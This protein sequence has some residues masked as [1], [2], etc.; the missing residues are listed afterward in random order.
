MEGKCTI[1]CFG[2]EEDMV[3]SL[4]LRMVEVVKGRMMG[5]DGCEWEAVTRVLRMTRIKDD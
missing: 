2:G 1:S 5:A 4:A 3:V